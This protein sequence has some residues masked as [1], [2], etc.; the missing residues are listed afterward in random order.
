MDALIEWIWD[1][2]YWHWWAFAVMLAAVEIIVPTTYLLWPAISAA[3]VGLAVALIGQFDW[4]LQVLAF[5]VLAVVVTVIGSRWWRKQPEA[6]RVSGLNARGAR[7]VGRRLHLAKEL[8]DGRGQVQ[9]DDTWWPARSESGEALRA[10]DMVEV[11][12]SDG[13][14]LVMRPVTAAQPARA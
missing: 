2:S 14:V 9:I 3:I 1:L 6:Q 11:V 4:R 5:A 12:A 8:A 13:A 10:G 7:Y